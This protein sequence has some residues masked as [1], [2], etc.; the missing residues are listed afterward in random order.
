MA[1]DR[2]RP[3]KFDQESAERVMRGVRKSEKLDRL[4]TSQQLHAFFSG[5][6][7]VTVKV[8]KDKDETE[9]YEGVFTYRNVDSDSPSNEW[10]DDSDLDEDEYVPCKVQAIN[11]EALDWKTPL[12]YAG[13]LIGGKNEDY[14]PNDP[15]DGA[16]ADGDGLPRVLAFPIGSD[17]PADSPSV[18]DCT[19]IN[20]VDPEDTKY[21]TFSTGAV[22]GGCKDV[23]PQT[24]QA[25]GDTDVWVAD[26]LFTLP[27]GQW[28]TRYYK[29]TC[30]LPNGKMTLTKE[31]D[32]TIPSGTV[33]VECGFYERCQSGALVWS[34]GGKVVCGENAVQPAYY[35]VCFA[36]FADDL[37]YLNVGMV[38][39]TKS[40]T[41]NNT[42]NGTVAGNP[43]VLVKVGSTFTLTVTASGGDVVYT[44]TAPD[45]YA[46]TVDLSFVSAPASTAPAKLTMTPPGTAPCDPG[47]IEILVS[48]G[49]GTV[50]TLCDTDAIPKT[51]CAT[52]LNYGSGMEDYIRRFPDTYFTGRRVE[53]VYGA[54]NVISEGPAVGW[55]G[56]FNGATEIFGRS[57]DSGPWLIEPVSFFLFLRCANDGGGPYWQLQSDHWVFFRGGGGAAIRCHST[58]PVSFDFYDPVTGFHVVIGEGGCKSQGACAV[59]RQYTPEYGGLGA[60]NPQFACSPFLTVGQSLTVTNDSGTSST[61]VSAG[62]GGNDVQIDVS[63]STS[64][65]QLYIDLST[66]LVNPLAN[67]WYWK[68]LSGP[69]PLLDNGAVGQYTCIPPVFIIILPSTGEEVRIAAPCTPSNPPPPPPPASYDCV[70]GVCVGRGDTSGA[71][72]TLTECVAAG[73]ASPPPPPPP[74]PPGCCTGTLPIGGTVTFP[75]AA[76]H[77]T[78]GATWDGGGA[79]AT[80]TIG[81]AYTIQLLCSGSSFLLNIWHDGTDLS[82]PPDESYA[83]IPPVDCA[84]NQVTFNTSGSPTLGP[85]SYTVSW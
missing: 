28:R 27:T 60:G 18:A 5:L 36:G 46:D 40:T 14:N 85:L 57:I 37:T 63:T 52:I 19:A 65:I 1:R 8:T 58:N 61:T 84:T 70:S 79:S 48:C 22:S 82:S 11:K 30:D 83:A 17:T 41:A 77:P 54:P 25:T 69:Q 33:V 35:M 4:Y 23:T 53:M 74:P 67:I 78:T 56:Y 71:Y 6:T 66:T 81:A 76:G 16:P 49:A 10:V 2:K 75:D 3:V 51:L 31:N 43:A 72:A 44:G 21:L 32:D 38:K 50:Q 34:F 12:R 62:T 73:C 39:L 13:I 20:H 7:L 15:D 47:T 59:K 80:F 26:D 55:V 42:W 64:T 9:W 45:D 68:T 29:K 24:T